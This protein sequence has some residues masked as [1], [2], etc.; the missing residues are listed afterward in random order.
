MWVIRTPWIEKRHVE[1]LSKGGHARRVAEGLTWRRVALGGEYAKS[2]QQPVATMAMLAAL[3]EVPSDEREGWLESCEDNGIPDR[4]A[5]ASLTECAR[6]ISDSNH[7]F[8][9]SMTARG[10]LI[11]VAC[12]YAEQCPSGLLQWSL[13]AIAVWN[14]RLT[15]EAVRYMLFESKWSGPRGCDDMLDWLHDVRW[16]ADMADIRVCANEAQTADRISAAS[17]TIEMMQRMLRTAAR[18]CSELPRAFVYSL[19][20]AAERVD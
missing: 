10:A 14:I 17:N 16:L 12:A 13:P 7:E 5:Q 1:A 8:H 19:R 20:V 11:D 9:S 2:A 15:A 18:H 3:L 6:R 4:T